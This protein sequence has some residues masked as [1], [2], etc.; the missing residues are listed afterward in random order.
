MRGVRGFV[1][2]LAIIGLSMT[3]S[4]QE[5]HVMS[6]QGY[7]VPVADYVTPAIGPETGGP[8]VFGISDWSVTSFR[9]ADFC[10]CR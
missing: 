9:A 7:L 3:V 5:S 6:P 1:L 4:A 10:E 2:V 8:D